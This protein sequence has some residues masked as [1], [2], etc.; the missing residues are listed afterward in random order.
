MEDRGMWKVGVVTL[1]AMIGVLGMVAFLVPMVRERVTG[2]RWHFY[3]VFDD[4]GGLQP[5][6]Q[7]TLAGVTIGTASSVQ[8]ITRAD[9]KGA[10]M[11]QK[12][13]TSRGLPPHPLPFALVKLAIKKDYEGQLYTY[14]KYE[15]GASSLI[16]TS[17]QVTVTPQT[18]PSEQA[19]VTDV[20]KANDIV[21]GGSA[22]SLS[23]M[24]RPAGNMMG[25][26]SRLSDTIQSLVADPRLKA[27]LMDSMQQ[28]D[29]AAR[30]LNAT[31]QNAR[32]LAQNASGTLNQSLPRITR[33]MQN[34]EDSTANLRTASQ[35]VPAMVDQIQG[36]LTRVRG[37][38]VSASQYADDTIKNVDDTSSS[39]KHFVAD[40]GTLHDLHDTVANFKASSA[41]LDETLA[42]VQKLTSNPQLQQD[43]PQIIANLKE[44]TAQLKP[45]IEQ[46]NKT[47]S[48]FQ[49]LG[50]TANTTLG[51][52]NKILPGGGGHKGAAEA[53]A[54]RPPHQN[55]ALHSGIGFLVA[56]KTSPRFPHSGIV[57]P[58]IQLVYG[59]SIFD[60]GVYD[61]GGQNRITAEV[62]HR[63]F[64]NS[65]TGV[66]LRY[67]LY[68][69]LAGLGG[70]FI[71]NPKLGIYATAYDP[72]LP[73]VDLESVLDL[74]SNL[75]LWAGID[76]INR[77][78]RPF[79]G[80]RV[81][82]H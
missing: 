18:A 40:T 41:K 68:R 74:S 17:H 59:P 5:A 29:D 25:S 46:A 72:N 67:G 55:L 69:G 4:A 64:G 26:I 16:G 42:N 21:F 61:I 63:F 44:A 48:T 52:I 6:E 77:D 34:V 36:S 57:D 51:G 28:I 81:L 7:V 19:Q 54:E 65:T 22:P 79:L 47:L 9:S 76:E 62:G 15:V 11:V 33:S 71:L 27:K 78:P 49:T 58:E 45:T 66:N 82:P 43:L 31:T 32:M 39:I 70:D 50:T 2:G 60:L 10:I 3:A 8:L 37:N 38:L 20:V 14:Y 24:A 56:H 73:S 12:Y 53:R 23:N 75:G 35:R 30:N 13:L 1:V 80:I